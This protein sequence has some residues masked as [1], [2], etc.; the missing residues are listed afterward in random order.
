M[1]VFMNC[2]VFVWFKDFNPGASC[3]GREGMQCMDGLLECAFLWELVH[4]IHFA[5]KTVHD[6]KSI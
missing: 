3:L 6:P 4:N 5:L 1:A 2:F